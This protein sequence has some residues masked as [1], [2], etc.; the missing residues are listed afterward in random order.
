MADRVHVMSLVRPVLFYFF[1]GLAFGDRTLLYGKFRL[2]LICVA[3]SL[4]LCI[5]L[6]QTLLPIPKRWL[7][8]CL[9]PGDDLPL[10]VRLQRQV[11][12]LIA[13]LTLNWKI[14]PA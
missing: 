5:K 10:T 7:G 11:F 1:L 2:G 14:L 8:V 9:V 12:C 13:L 4:R 3:H 6:H